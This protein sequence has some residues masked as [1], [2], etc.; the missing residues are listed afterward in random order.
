[1]NHHAQGKLC[2]DLQPSITRL[3]AI[4]CSYSITSNSPKTSTYIHIYNIKTINSLFFHFSSV[5][6]F[7]GLSHKSCQACPIQ[8]LCTRTA[9]PH[10]L[11]SNLSLLVGVSQFLLSL[12]SFRLLFFSLFFSV[13]LSLS[14]SLSISSFCRDCRPQLPLSRAA[15][16]LSPTCAATTNTN[17]QRSTVAALSR[18]S[19]RQIWGS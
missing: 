7:P 8:Q 15:Y 13:F 12:S 14:Q 1:M 3:L 6:V 5:S 2:G 9:N 19:I 18:K 10:I 16:L 4:E 17:T 11:V